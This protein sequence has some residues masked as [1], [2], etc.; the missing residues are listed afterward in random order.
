M[1]SLLGT[2][3]HSLDDKGRIILPSSFRDTFAAGAYLT[4]G[5]DGCLTLMGEA[6]F[7]E[8]VAHR[9]RLA[10]VSRQYRHAARSFTAGSIGCA[11]DKQGRLA[12][13]AN[14]R[15]YAGL[16][17]ACVVIGSNNRV[18]IWSEQRWA[19]VDEIGDATLMEG[20]EI[21]PALLLLIEQEANK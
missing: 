5:T 4:K 1:T 13:P 21:D 17:K 3:E 18:E 11:P 7:N 20:D 15:E 8:Q 19:E 9:T 14:L 16:E 12:I 10:K 2:F 6:E